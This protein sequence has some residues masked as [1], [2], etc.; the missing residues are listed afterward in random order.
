MLAEGLYSSGSGGSG[1]AV[2]GGD[3]ETGGDC[4]Q[5]GEIQAKEPVVLKRPYT[6]TQQ[7]I[8]EHMP[9][10]L[11]YRAW[12]PHC[13][14]GRGVTGHHVKSDKAER[15]GAT[16][17]MDYC[18]LTA[19]ERTEDCCPVLVLYDDDLE[20]IYALPVESKSLSKQVVD[21]CVAKIDEGGALW[22]ESNP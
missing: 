18:F 8:A 21:W 22:R 2:S 12:C 14:A 10:H 7:E 9:L 19:T 16:I 15:I 5:N 17:S 11:P 20:A 4:E 13:V 1:G 6:P 3:G